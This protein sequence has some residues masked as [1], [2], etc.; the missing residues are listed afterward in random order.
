MAKRHRK[1]RPVSIIVT[2]GALLS[3]FGVTV[4]APS[5]AD[6]DRAEA[7]LRD[8]RKVELVNLGS[9]FGAEPATVRW[10]TDVPAGCDAVSIELNGRPVA[11]EGTMEAQRDSFG[12]ADYWLQARYGAKADGR[13]RGLG[14]TSLLRGRIVSYARQGDSIVEVPTGPG[15]DVAARIAHRVLGAVSEEVRTNIV[16]VIEIHLIPVGVSMTDLPAFASLRGQTTC[17]DGTI[18]GCVD[19]RP[20]DDVRGLH[21]GR[22]LERNAVVAA[23]GV[24]DLVMG[25]DAEPGQI[26][27]YTLVHELAHAVLRHGLPARHAE[28]E[29]MLATQ[30]ARGFE[31]NFIGGD[32]YTSSNIDEYFAESSTAYLEIAPHEVF[33]VEHTRETLGAYDPPMLDLLRSVYPYA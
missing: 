1:A 24:E 23:T 7:C 22:Y 11:R 33:R 14:V 25:P 32:E 21:W 9:P 30:K 31:A 15:A 12:G 20:W 26:P 19:D 2:I 8:T 29:A 18:A 13:T 10:K 16:N 28:V 4:A 27:G 6:D 3:V 17:A 5:W